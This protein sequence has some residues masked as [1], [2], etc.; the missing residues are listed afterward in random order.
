MMSKL[1]P[2]PRACG[3]LPEGAADLFEIANTIK[4][5]LTCPQLP[6]AVYREVA[7]HLRQIMGVKV[8][9]IV[10]SPDLDSEKFDYA[11][12]QIAALWLEF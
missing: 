9:L 2:T 4:T 12:S 3:A 10:R 11:Q 6:L 7:A 8:G 5:Q 1:Q